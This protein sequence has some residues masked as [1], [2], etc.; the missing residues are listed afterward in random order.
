MITPNKAPK[1]R[2]N[3][4]SAARLITF[5]KAFANNEMPKTIIINTKNTVEVRRK[6]HVDLDIMEGT[7]IT[8]LDITKFT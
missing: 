3:S 7:V 2:L 1:N 8:L 5:V 4:P 6:L